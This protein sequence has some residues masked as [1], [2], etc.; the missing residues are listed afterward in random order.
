MQANLLQSL[1]CEMATMMFLD[2]QTVTVGTPLGKQF[3]QSHPAIISS[4]NSFFL[5]GKLIKLVH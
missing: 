4:F 1:G 5:Y 2:G 3:L